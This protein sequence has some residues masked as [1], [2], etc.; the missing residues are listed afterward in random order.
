M[1]FLMAETCVLIFNRIR[2]EV[3][4]MT[5]AYIKHCYNG[6]QSPPALNHSLIPPVLAYLE[7]LSDSERAFLNLQDLLDPFQPPA[8][9]GF[10]SK[11]LA[12]SKS[13]G[14]VGH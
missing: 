6:V 8:F 4:S 1:S 2:M 10:P 3:V 11:S 7:F 12:N 5:T 13:N 14:R 9:T